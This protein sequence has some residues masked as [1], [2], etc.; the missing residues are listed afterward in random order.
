MLF[1]KGDIVCLTEGEYSNYGISGIYRVV[2]AFDSDEAEAEFERTA[3]KYVERPRYR[4]GHG[5][6]EIS[7]DGY[8]E[9]LK[10]KKLIE[11]IVAKEYFIGTGGRFEP[12][13]NAV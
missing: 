3:A 1:N 4:H 7:S 8:T 11:E 5:T 2:H 13:V 6:D 9:W 10:A 12:S